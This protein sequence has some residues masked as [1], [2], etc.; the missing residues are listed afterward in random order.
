MFVYFSEAVQEKA[1]MGSA[2][3]KTMDEKTFRATLS[4]ALAYAKDSEG[5][6]TQRKKKDE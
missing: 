3:F 2:V 6:R 4:S 5:G 1:K